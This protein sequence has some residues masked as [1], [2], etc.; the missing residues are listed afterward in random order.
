MHGGVRVGVV[1]GWRGGVGESVRE[2]ECVGSDGFRAVS[3]K[4]AI[5]W[6]KE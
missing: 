2:V 5:K 4:W 1:E 3:I 6:G